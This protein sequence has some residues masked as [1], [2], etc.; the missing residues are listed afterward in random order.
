MSKDKKSYDSKELFLRGILSFGRA[1]GAF[2]NPMGYAPGF[3]QVHR[4][5]DE[6]RKRRKSHAKFKVQCAA[7]REQRR[8]ES[9]R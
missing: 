8:L 3:D 7:R 5:K 4:T 2:F 9:L 1:I 6:D